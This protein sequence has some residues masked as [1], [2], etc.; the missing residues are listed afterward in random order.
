V[1]NISQSQGDTHSHTFE[2]AGQYDVSCDV[3][4][5]MQATIVAATTPYA[6]FADEK[7]TFAFQHVTPG[8]YRLRVSVDGRDIERVINV[9]GAALDVSAANP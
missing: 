6:M 8:E 1:L 5:G 4:P 7:G 3:H 2:Q 9:A